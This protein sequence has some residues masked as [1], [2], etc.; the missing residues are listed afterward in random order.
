MMGYFKDLK[1][2]RRIVM[3]TMKN[4]HPIYSI[5]EL[6]IKRELAKNPEL[7]NESWDRFLP[8]FKKRNVKRR[9]PKVINKK[10]EEYSTFPPEQQLRKEDYQMMTGEYFLSKG[11]KE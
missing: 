1:Q 8:H 11:A 7:A 10:K 5:K 6:M 2:V 3:D 9:K 4:I